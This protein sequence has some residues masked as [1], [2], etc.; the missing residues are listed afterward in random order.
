MLAWYAMTPEEVA[1]AIR[2][3]EAVAEDR[4]L[5]AGLA[6]ERRAALVRAAGR[7]SRPSPL[8]K[9]RLH[10]ALRRRDTLGTRARDEA[11][12]GETGM[13]TAARASAWKEPPRSE[14]RTVGEL[15]V[16]RS[17]YVCKEAF[18]APPRL[19]RFDVPGRAPR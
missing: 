8:E 5:L 12:L 4:G 13:R 18:R 15:A 7:V 14:P 1:T 9:R 17:C 16:A 6:P 2:V 19:L 10:K 11:L 3:L